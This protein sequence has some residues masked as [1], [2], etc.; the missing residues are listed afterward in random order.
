[1]KQKNET[2]APIKL[3]FFM[4]VFGSYNLLAE[5]FWKF[6]SLATIFT[7]ISM[8]FSF[9]GGQEFMCIN[10]A[11]RYKDLCYDNLGLF[12]GV[13]LLL[14]VLFLMFLSRWYRYALLNEKMTLKLLFVP[15]IQD[16]K[17]FG[18]FLAYIL[19]FAIAIF[20]FYLLLKRVPNPNWQIELCYFTFVSLGFLVPILAWRFLV[21]FAYAVEEI[22]FPSLKYIWKIT[23]R[24]MLPII[25]FWCIFFIFML[26]LLQISLRFVFMHNPTFYNAVLVEYLSTMMV[27]L[28]IACFMNYCYLQKNFFDKG[29]LNEPT[30]R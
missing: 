5:K 30:K 14:F 8:T 29:N 9:I 2:P 21:Y 27:F 17:V 24:N 3:P 7:G 16:L 22:T 19:T 11:F 10:R 18:L 12:F 13:H 1:M 28:V 6:I 20:S 4:T 25:S 15:T 23:S 26:F